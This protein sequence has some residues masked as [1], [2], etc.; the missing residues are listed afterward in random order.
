M[1][2]GYNDVMISTGNTRSVYDMSMYMR[3]GTGLLITG[4][5]TDDAF[6]LNSD[7]NEGR[8]LLQEANYSLLGM[9]DDGRDQVR[10]VLSTLKI[11]LM[12][13]LHLLQQN[14]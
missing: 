11:I 13:P 5:T 7:N 14:N 6:H 8:S 4:L 1:V 9:E 10:V 3:R 2:Y 12:D